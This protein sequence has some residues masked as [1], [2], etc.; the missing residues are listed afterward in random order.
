MPISDLDAL[1]IRWGQSV[2]YVFGDVEGVTVGMAHA[3]TL[4]VSADDVI[5]AMLLT[6]DTINGAK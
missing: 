3:H 2:R 5:A 1:V 6:A 4:P